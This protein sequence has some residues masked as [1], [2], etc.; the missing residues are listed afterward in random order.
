[1][2][3]NTDKK[4]KFQSS[5]ILSVNKT[6]VLFLLFSELTFENKTFQLHRESLCLPFH[7]AAGFFQRLLLVNKYRHKLPRVMN[8][9]IVSNL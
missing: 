1:M 6:N 8:A 3:E 4:K 7:F 9:Y 5:E 2:Q